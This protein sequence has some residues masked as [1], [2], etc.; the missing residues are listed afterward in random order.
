MLFNDHVRDC[1]ADGVAPDP[2]LLLLDGDETA[3][4][5]PSRAKK[6]FNSWREFWESSGGIM[7]EWPGVAGVI[8]TR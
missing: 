3:A 8:G 2:S 4:T 7:E 6:R 5:L 1:D